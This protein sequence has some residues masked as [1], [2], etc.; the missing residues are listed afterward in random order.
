MLTCGYFERG[1]SYLDKALQMFEAL[2]DLQ[3]LAVAL[4]MLG[5][6]NQYNN[7]LGM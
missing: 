5:E 6:K 7:D 4:Y 1:T 3:G 2:N